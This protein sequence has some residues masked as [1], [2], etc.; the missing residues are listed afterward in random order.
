MLHA[1]LIETLTLDESLVRQR[2]AA[3]GESCA[4]RLEPRPAG[5]LLWLEES[6]AAERL[7]GALLGCGWVR[8]LNFAAAQPAYDLAG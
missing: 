2:L 3:L 7:C 8:R 4:W 1:V 6:A 5:W